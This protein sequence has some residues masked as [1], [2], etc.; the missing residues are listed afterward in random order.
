MSFHDKN[1]DTV[2]TNTVTFH[3]WNS[4]SAYHMW[5]YIIKIQDVQWTLN[6]CVTLYNSSATVPLTALVFWF[7][8]EITQSSQGKQTEITS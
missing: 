6:I 7:K 1:H 8:V 4:K 3:S 2:S 5:Y